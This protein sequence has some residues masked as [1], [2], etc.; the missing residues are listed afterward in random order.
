MSFFGSVASFLGGKRG[1]R[2]RA[3]VADIDAHLVGR[4]IGK[5]ILGE[6]PFLASRLGWIEAH[7]IGTFDASK[8]VG[9]GLLERMWNNPG[10]FPPATEGFQSFYHAYTAALAQADLIGLMRCPHEDAVV[11]K[12]APQAALC[13]L[14]DL[15]PYYHPAPWSQYLAERRVL[16]VHPFASTI[17]AQFKSVR[18]KLFLDP[19]VLPEFQLLTLLPPQTL[20]GNDGGFASWSQAL[21]HLC[22]EV[23]Q[24]DFEVAIVGCGAYGLPL[25]A[26]IKSQL[27]RPCIHLGGA[28]Q[29]LFGISGLRWEKMA[30]FRALINEHWC[31]PA[32]EERP[33]NWQKVESGCYW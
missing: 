14:R 10:F 13:E 33:T 4:E 26:F 32:L 1:D 22:Q 20:A 16:V 27:R 30:S 15:E 25:G 9:G 18:R 8:T 28:T 5:A 12:Y 29:L 3:L 19:E 21:E 23:V 7:A 2:R 11:S 31:R 6:K 24:H 17:E